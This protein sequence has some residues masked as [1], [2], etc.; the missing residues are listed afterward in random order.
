MEKLLH[1]LDARSISGWY[2]PAM[3]MQNE[4][5]AS[6]EREIALKEKVRIA[7]NI[8]KDK[9]HIPIQLENINATIEEKSAEP[10]DGEK[11]TKPD[12]MKYDFPVYFSQYLESKDKEIEQLNL[13]L[14][15]SVEK[16]RELDIQCEQLQ[17]FKNRLDEIVNS[18]GNSEDE[19]E[20]LVAKQYE[21]IL[22]LQ[23]ELKINEKK[24]QF[25]DDD[26]R[27]IKA[28][29]K[30][31]KEENNRLIFELQKQLI[32]KNESLKKYQKHKC[33]IASKS[34]DIEKDEMIS[35]ITRLKTTLG[36]VSGQFFKHLPAVDLKNLSKINM[37]KI[38]KYGVI[39]NES[40][41][42]FITKKEYTA[43]EYK[44][45]LIAKKNNELQNENEHL[46]ELLDVYQNQVIKNYLN[47]STRPPQKSKKIQEFAFFHFIQ[48][49]RT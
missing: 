32:D 10:V 11:D 16:Y 2:H 8:L 23:S 39:E 25:F 35:E 47:E 22:K 12:T 48:I 44:C 7:E 14:N 34:F 40:L 15:T 30:K 18:L 9:S 21:E 28:S 37:D 43:L 19:K 24:I 31:S 17:V 49:S 6:K 3:R 4:L 20:I 13:Q 41:I 42:H 29:S 5:I 1:A 27:S 26:Y 33:P 46:T 45:E 38:E 36:Q